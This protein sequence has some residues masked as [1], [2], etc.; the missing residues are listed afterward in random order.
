MAER[1]AES[2]TV[3][4]TKQLWA[5]HSATFSG[6]ASGFPATLRWSSGGTAGADARFLDA[7][8]VL[9]ASD[10]EINA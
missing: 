7:A 3:S 1:H 4:L 6:D 5:Y 8:A 2:Y 10:P 9:L